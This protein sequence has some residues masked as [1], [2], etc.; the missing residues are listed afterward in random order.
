ML[1][2]S[3]SHKEENMLT[4]SRWLLNMEQQNEEEGRPLENHQ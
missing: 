4:E 1:L 2:Q 3:K